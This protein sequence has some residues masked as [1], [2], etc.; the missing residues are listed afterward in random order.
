[1]RDDMERSPRDAALEWAMRIEEPDFDDW[2]AHLAWLE[3][4]PANPRLYRNASIALKDGIAA[5]RDVEPLR[6]ANDDGTI[7]DAP[8][9]RKRGAWLAVMTGLAASAVVVL[10]PRQTP[11]ARDLVHAA[12]PGATKRIPLA[13]GSVLTLNGGAV[14]RVLGGNPRRLRLE[15]GEVFVEVARDADHPFRL[16]AS[17]SVFEDVGTAFNAR[18]DAGVVS[19]AVAE[20]VVAY[21][22][23]AAAVRMPAGQSITVG[24]SRA[25]LGRTEPSTVGSWRSG[26]LIYTGA[27]MSRVATDLSAALGTTIHLSDNVANKRFTGV[28]VLR[29]SDSEVIH[30]FAALGGISGR[31]DGKEWKMK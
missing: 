30:R 24:T 6:A 15:R 16:L 3:K 19:L 4:D 28:I 5:V 27:A 29:G 26:R 1:M 11:V 18:L 8:P 22:P 25:V 9:L 31:L 10:L 14:V 21:D 2:D 12:A 23:D 17:T 20:G 13:D 7:V